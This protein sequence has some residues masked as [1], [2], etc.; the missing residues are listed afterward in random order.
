MRGPASSPRPASP[1]APGRTEPA[2]HRS[3]S[4]DDS[5][6]RTDPPATGEPEHSTPRI[7]GALLFS[8][9]RTEAIGVTVDGA[10]RTHAPDG[11]RQ[12]MR[13]AVRRLF[14]VRPQ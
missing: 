8:P 12:L 7:L 10:C 9:S 11:R 6:S 4:P 14:S 1:P 2:K 5:P 13:D 3:R